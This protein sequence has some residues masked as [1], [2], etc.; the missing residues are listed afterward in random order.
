[1]SNICLKCKNLTLGYQGHARPSSRAGAL[2]AIK[3][4]IQV[5]NVQPFIQTPER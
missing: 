3:N 5:P 1:M 2:S 4:G